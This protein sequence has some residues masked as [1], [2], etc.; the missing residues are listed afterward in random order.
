MHIIQEILNYDQT[1]NHPFHY[2]VSKRSLK[3]RFIFSRLIDMTFDMRYPCV[4]YQVLFRACFVITLVTCDATAQV[5]SL[6]KSAMRE[7]TDQRPN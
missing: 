3:G 5:V 6:L 2:S 1:E 4:L 7:Q